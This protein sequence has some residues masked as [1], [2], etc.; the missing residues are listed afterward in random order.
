MPCLAGGSPFLLGGSG[1]RGHRLV[2]LADLAVGGE[3]AAVLLQSELE[4]ALSRDEEVRGFTGSS[5]GAWDKEAR[6]M[7][8]YEV[9]ALR[10]Q[11]EDLSG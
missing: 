11:V 2:V 6:R 7:A 5:E 8:E 4:V 9:A 1:R 3:A 10:Q